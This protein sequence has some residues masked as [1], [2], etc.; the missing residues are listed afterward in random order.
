MLA[1]LILSAIGADRLLTNLE[2]KMLKDALGLDGNGIQQL[3]DMYNEQMEYLV[4]HFADNMG[5]DIKTDVIMLVAVFSAV[6][7]KICKEESELLRKLLH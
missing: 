3:I 2:R 4:N 7:E 5:E 1:S 6:D